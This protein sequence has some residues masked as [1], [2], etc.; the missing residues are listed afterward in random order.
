[1][2]AYPPG[3]EPPG[4]TDHTPWGMALGQTLATP[5]LPDPQ[6]SP[7]NAAPPTWVH[8]VPA[9]GGA[10]ASN[11]PSPA[12]EAALTTPTDLLLQVCHETSCPCLFVHLWSV[13]LCAHQFSLSACTPADS[14]DRAPAVAIHPLSPLATTLDNCIAGKC[15]QTLATKVFTGASSH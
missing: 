14:C 8:A 6:T 11:S 7:P 15:L 5:R 13:T 4:S 2:H 1:M 12:G 10:Y 3:V 9:G